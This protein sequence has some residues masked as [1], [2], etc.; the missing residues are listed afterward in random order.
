MCG[1]YMS[2]LACR[3][4]NFLSCSPAFLCTLLF[5]LSLFRSRYG[6][7]YEALDNLTGRHVALKKI[8]LEMEDEGIPTFALREITLLTNLEHENVVKLENVI[9]E[10][11]RL[12]LIF[13]LVDM[14]LKKLM[15]MQQGMISPALVQSY[16][17]QMLAGLS[18]CHSVGVMHRDLKPQ[19]ILVTRDGG[20][21]I[22]DFGLARCFT[23]YVKPLTMEVITIWYRAPEILLGS[24]VYTCA[25]DLW[26]I[27]CIVAEMANKRAFFTGL[28]EIDQLHHIFNVLGTPSAEDWAGV[29]D[30]PY[31]RPCFPDW[32]PKALERLVPSIGIP[33]A[34]LLEQLFIF[35]PLNRITAVAALQHP[36]VRD[37]L[38]A[39]AVQSAYVS[40]AEG[41]H[42]HTARQQHHQHQGGQS[43]A[44][45]ANKVTPDMATLPGAGGGSGSGSEPCAECG[46]GTGRSRSPN[47]ST[48]ISSQGTRC[49]SC[50]LLRGGQTLSISRTGAATVAKAPARGGVKELEALIP[51]N[52]DT[53][54][55]WTGKGG[56]TKATKVAGGF[57]KRPE[58]QSSSS[59][60][61]L[62]LAIEKEEESEDSNDGSGGCMDSQIQ[63]GRGKSKVAKA[64]AQEDAVSNRLRTGAC[65]KAKTKSTEVTLDL[66]GNLGTVVSRGPPVTKEQLQEGLRSG[67][68]L[69]YAPKSWK[70]ND[71]AL[72]QSCMEFASKN[73][74]RARPPAGSLKG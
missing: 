45:V 43:S 26:S 23:P 60:D 63:P 74:K 68:F 58:A 52:T 67:T 50:N 17:Y 18:Y 7:V 73:K 31:W 35:D 8:R 9:S 37:D 41:P 34:D 25:V 3:V 30:L 24:N 56:I 59:E 12:Y 28:S 14:D 40:P 6:V 49:S 39:Q 4:R 42:A 20:L 44:A 53:R 69:M 2:V 51:D 71:E 64:A 70:E 11:S 15:D 72:Q 61:A 10:P 19:N 13:E 55:R 38:G 32:P 33:G 16:T 46:G 22:A 47:S 66:K 29:S 27:G 5:S 21:K 36:Y 1:E 48:S 57:A 65:G 54:N 62:G